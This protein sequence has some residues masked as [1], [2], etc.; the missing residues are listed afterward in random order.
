MKN[1]GN[2]IEQKEKSVYSVS[3]RVLVIS[4]YLDQ[5]I[6]IYSP[7]P[8]KLFMHSFSLS[9]YVVLYYVNWEM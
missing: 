8:I 7:K 3:I 9:F 1:T 4:H 5:F 2:Y 6:L